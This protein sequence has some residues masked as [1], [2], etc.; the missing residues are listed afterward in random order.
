[1]ALSEAARHCG[2]TVCDSTTV[3]DLKAMPISIALHL[4]SSSEDFGWAIT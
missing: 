1:M 4:T 3:A 2:L